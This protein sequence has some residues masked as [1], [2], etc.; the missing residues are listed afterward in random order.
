M[1]EHHKL[2]SEEFIRMCDIVLRPNDKKAIY[3][4]LADS[5]TASDPPYWMALMGGT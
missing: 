5:S 4:T 3:G 2:L 1:V